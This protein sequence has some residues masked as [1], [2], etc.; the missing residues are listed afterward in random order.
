[1]DEDSDKKKNLLGKKLKTLEIL[2]NE[3]YNKK[4]DAPYYIFTNDDVKAAC[5]Q[6]KFKNP[7]DV[8][9]VDSIYDLPK[10]MQEKSY[11]MFHLGGG[12]HAFIMGEGYHEFEKVSKEN[13]ITFPVKPRIVDNI[14]ESEA[15]SLSFI[16]NKGII[17]DF[18]SVHNSSMNINI[19]R[20]SRVTFDFKVGD[21]KLH[22]AGQQIEID[23]IFDTEDGMIATVEAKNKANKDFEIRQLFMVQK[24]FDMLAEKKHI[25]EK[26]KLHILF[27]VKLQHQNIYRLYEYKFLDEDDMNSIRLVKA[28]E[29]NIVT[30]GKTT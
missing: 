4:P 8:T 15:G 19:A 3:R 14:G 21:K 2:F 6:T 10:T 17:Q 7:F 22:I 27:L 23:G 11:F 25:P 16:F 13:S 30:A 1:M 9:K 18:L 5:S 24:Y 20:R 26:I 28:K 12:T 29:Y